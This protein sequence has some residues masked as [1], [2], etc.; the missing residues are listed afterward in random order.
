MLGKLLEVNQSEKSISVVTTYCPS[1]PCI[2]KIS[3]LGLGSGMGVEGNG[4]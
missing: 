3:V 1:L 4:C 2:L